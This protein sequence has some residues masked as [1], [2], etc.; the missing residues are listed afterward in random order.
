[1]LG[2]F[3][4]LCVCAGNLD[5]SVAVIGGLCGK[6]VGI[7]SVGPVSLEYPECQV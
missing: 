3:L 4:C 6:V 2:L 7:L 1:M 5:P